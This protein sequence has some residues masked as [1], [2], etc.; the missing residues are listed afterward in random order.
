MR[1][2]VTVHLDVD[3]SAYLAAI[4]RMRLLL[5]TPTVRHWISHHAPED[6]AASAIHAAYDRRRR[7]RRRRTR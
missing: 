3:V 1:G 2:Q 4:E 5:A 7:A 6:P